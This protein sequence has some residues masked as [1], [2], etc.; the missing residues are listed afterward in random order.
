[1]NSNSDDR[2]PDELD[3]RLDSA[4]QQWGEQFTA[5]ESVIEAAKA[6]TLAAFADEPMPE[7]SSISSH[8]TEHW[9]VIASLAATIAILALGGWWFMQQSGVKV[10]SNQI[11]S[12]A[13]LKAQSDPEKQHVML[14]RFRELF[15]DQLN[16][17]S[18]IDNE[19]QISLG[20]SDESRPNE[21]DFLAVELVL[22]SRSL[23]A[24]EPDWNIEHRAS[25]L[26]RSEQRVDSNDPSGPFS[27]SFWAL[28]VEDDFISI[29]L[30]CRLP[31][32]DALEVISSDLQRSGTANQIHAFTRSGTE[33]RLYQTGTR[34]GA[35]SFNDEALHSGNA[36]SM[37]AMSNV[38]GAPR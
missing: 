35:A 15:G 28:S 3:H 11:D 12:A 36:F 9:K 37:F 20:E 31:G 6:K 26:A 23:K 22:I 27:F 25:V 16:F 14:A 29:D 30:Q 38:P 17:V 32:E 19:V 13:L 21:R 7:K 8:R 34:I 33:Y 4:L 5:D 1:M 2:I 24:I 10:A 18:E